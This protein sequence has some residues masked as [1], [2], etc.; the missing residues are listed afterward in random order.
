MKFAGLILAAFMALASSS[1]AR[2]QEQTAVT[3][4]AKARS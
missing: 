1:F 3:G 2:A 4:A